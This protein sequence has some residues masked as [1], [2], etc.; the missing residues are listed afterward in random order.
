MVFEAIRKNP[1][2]FTVAPNLTDY[3]RSCASFSWE[4]TERELTKLP[5]SRGL[6]IAY[7]C[8]DRHT[9]GPR[10]NHL[11]L[12]W[13]GK[14]G[15]VLDY[16]YADLR[17]LTNR[18]ANALRAL[19]VGK[20]DR[21]FVLAGRI[22]EL[23]IA[24]LGTLKNGS[25]FC[26][27][28][29]AFGPEPIQ[30]RLLIGAGNVLVTTEALYS[31]RKISELRGSLPALKHVL[32]IGSGDMTLPPNTENF[33]ELMHAASEEFT[34]APTEPEDMA[35]I[36]FT[37]GTTGKPKGAVHVHQAVIAHHIT[38]KYALDFHPDDV[39]WCTADPG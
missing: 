34:V 6:N 31:R 2:N 3:A 15:E 24:A 25:V 27:L 35:L 16:T 33:H 28:F 21:V 36:H 8:V 14:Q 37:S 5:N 13:L 17:R 1:K 23:Y 12:R 22:P 32:V 19:G 30:Q 39:F 38:G 11:A 26:P 29:S 10:R 18:F 20:G 4:K 7:E 9:Q